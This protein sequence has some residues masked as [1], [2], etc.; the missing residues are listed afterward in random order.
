M[1]N[2][3]WE[4]IEQ[5]YHGAR[6]LEGDAR[7]AYLSEACGADASLRMQVERLL[8]EQPDSNSLFARPAAEFPTAVLLQSPSTVAGASSKQMSGHFGAYTILSLIGVGGMGE[9]YRASDTRLGRDVAIK[10]LPAAFTI[11]R[12]RLTRFEREARILASLP[13]SRTPK[14]FRSWILPLGGLA[15]AAAFLLLIEPGDQTRTDRLSTERQP[16]SGNADRIELVSPGPDAGV[17]ST[18]INFVWRRYD[19][20]SYRIV[21]SDETGHVLHQQSTSDTTLT[22]SLEKI[23]AAPGK[24]Y[25][26][27]DALSENGST[28]SSGLSEFELHSR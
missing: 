22:V 12:G 9:V 18:A 15:A 4:K 26:A 21:I 14:A 13:A 2:D 1:K 20:A 10:V 17:V 23:A 8:G 16:A 5:L 27:V 3:A 24:L 28:I 25:W 11:D 7:A 6:G 19:G